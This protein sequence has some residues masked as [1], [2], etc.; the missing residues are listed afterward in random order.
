MGKE[1]AIPSKVG[2]QLFIHVDKSIKTG[3]L[4]Q[5]AVQN[6]IPPGLNVKGPTIRS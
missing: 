2:G 4:L 3:P 1:W 6:V 5:E